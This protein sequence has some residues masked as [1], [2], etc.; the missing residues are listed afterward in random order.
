MSALRSRH[1]IAVAALAALAALIATWTAAAAP[2]DRAATPRG[3]IVTLGETDLG[4]VLIDARGRTLYLYTPDTKKQST[5]YGQCAAFWPPLL[6]V[7]KPRA[8]HGVKA[9]LLGTTKRKDGKLQVT[10]AGHPLYFFAQDAAPGDVHGQGLQNIWYALSAAGARVA[11]APPAATLQLAQ[12]SLGSILVDPRGMT[13]YL[14]NRDSGGTSAC[15]G[16]CATTWPPLLLSGKLRAG[17]GLQSS[18][19]GTTQ[20]TDGTTQV[21]YAGHPLYFYSRDTKAGD[22]T[23]QGVG[24][25]WYVVSPSGAQIGG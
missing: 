19:L 11:A 23:G 6:T 20:R 2:S 7:G 17:A 12:G 24:S 21:T 13:L 16:Q 25:I 10:Y 9:S 3:P 1:V 15:Y 5:C 18:L 22:T 4:R 8:A 14:F